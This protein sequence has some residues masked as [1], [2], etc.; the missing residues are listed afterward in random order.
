MS[1]DEK[2]VEF[3]LRAKRATYAG[4]GPESAP[5]RPASHDLRY[6]E[7]EMMYMD[8]YLGGG[9]FAGQEALWRRGVPLW[10]MNYAGQ[11]TGDP[12]SGDF[13]KQALLRGTPEM[14][15]RGPAYYAEGDWEYRCECEGDP[16]WFAGRES[17]TLKGREVYR[18][19]FHGGRIR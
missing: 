19:Q 18:C 12:F 2:T 16:D 13:L 6:E 3:L 9:D 7:G 1:M 15:Y 14:P 10:A 4:K 17:I 8:T 11:V 5:C